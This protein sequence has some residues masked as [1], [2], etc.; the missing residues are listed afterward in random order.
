MYVS[1]Y[2]D[3]ATAPGASTGGLSASQLLVNE[4]IVILKNDAIL[5]DVAA[6]L[7]EQGNGYVLTNSAIRGA[8]S[9]S[10]VDE[11]AMLN[12]AATTTDPDLSKAICDAFAAVAPAQLMEVMEMGTIKPMELA[13]PGAKVG[14]NITK[15]AV[16]GA[17]VG[18]AL[19]C[20]VILLVAM[21]DNTVTGERDLKRRL[22]VAVLGEV[23]SLQPSKKGE[24]KNGTRK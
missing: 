18:F 3:I 8:I 7:R 22:D 6:H 19:A 9:M 16:L 23:P 13:K 1:N 20:G 2:T 24:K 17:V 10:S 15:N 5:S 12:I 4:Y 11:T 21:L 14:P